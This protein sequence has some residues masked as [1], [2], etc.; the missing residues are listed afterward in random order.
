MRRDALPEFVCPRCHGDLTRVPEAYECHTCR[1][2]YPIVLGIPDFRV[3]PDPW[4]GLDDD[5]DKA[6]RL[7]ALVANQSFE[8]AVRTYWDITP[9]T[10]PAQAQRYIE[11]VLGAENRANEWWERMVHT[12]PP[13]DAGC[14]LDLGC[15]TADMVATGARHGVTLVGID[16]ALRWLVVAARRGALEGRSDQLV[17]ANAEFLP[18]KAA[19]FTRVVSLGLLE[20]CRDA[21]AVT[22]EAHRVSRPGAVMTLRTVNR[23][24]LL[25][26]PHVGVWGVGFVP[27]AW[28]DRYVQWRSNLRYQHHRL[29]SPREV[30]RSLRAAGFRNVQVDA[31]E[32]LPAD[33]A[34]LSPAAHTI[35]PAYALLRQ[36]PLVRTLLRVVAPLL[37]ARGEAT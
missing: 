24:S 7:A 31:A 28:A 21:V 20:H 16:V 6:R 36:A 33:E 15:G 32:M 1:V 5:R 8:D 34:R 2:A 26:E 22:S 14:W 23:F 13:A 37:Q 27:R 3:A 9:S 11:H 12:E 35:A 18:F 4:I 19:T 30:R 25:P 10:A 17:C 29:L